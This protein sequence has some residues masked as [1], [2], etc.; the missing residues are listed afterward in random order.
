MASKYGIITQADFEEYTSYDYSSFVN[1]ESGDILYTDAY[2]LA[3]ISHWE[4]FVTVWVRTTYAGATPNDSAK[5]VVKSL[6]KIDIDNQLIDDGFL[7]DVPKIDPMFYFSQNT[8]LQDLLKPE[9]QKNQIEDYESV[10]EYS[11]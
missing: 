9:Q 3:R 8:V 5:F 10:E 4:E 7:Q 1:K 11:G 6:C 2:V